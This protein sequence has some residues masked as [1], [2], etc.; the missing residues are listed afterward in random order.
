[1]KAKV[2][3]SF[4]F[5]NL[6]MLLTISSVYAQEEKGQIVIEESCY[7]ISLENQEK[8]LEIIKDKVYPFW[9][10]MKEM[11][12][13]DGD[14]KIYTQRVH[15]LKPNWTFKTI[16]RFKNYASIDKWLKERDTVVNKL[17]PNQGGYESIRKEISQIT[18]EHWD[19]L[20]REI[21]LN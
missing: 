8:F 11:G 1:M 12:V 17:F 6:I 3:R 19:E 9:V 20:I 10:E 2:C 4:I 18:E 13:I 21:P 5:S 16:V 15:T 7:L 14:F